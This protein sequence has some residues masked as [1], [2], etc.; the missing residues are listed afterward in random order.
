MS[1]ED[2]FLTVKQD[3]EASIEEAKLLVDSFQRISQ[4]SAADSAEVQQTLQDID[5]VLEEIDTDITD[6]QESVEVVSK[7]PQKYKVTSRE[8]DK[9]RDT[10][11]NIKRETQKLK[12]AAHPPKH[13]DPFVSTEDPQ[14]PGMSEEDREQEEMYQQQILNEQDTQLDSVFYTV[15]NLRQQANTMGQELEEHAE[16]LEEFEVAVDKSASRL[17]RGMK[18]VEIFL[19]KN[20]DTRSNCCIGVLIAVLII[21]LVLAVLI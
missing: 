5:Q 13:Q 16:M 10:I 7:D 14:D 12:D 15:G 20:E 17:S 21:F 9:R 19:K 8:V 1:S 18:Q 6:L 3:V 4:T 11:A 2:P